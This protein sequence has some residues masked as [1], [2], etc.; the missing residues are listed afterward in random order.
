MKKSLGLAMAVSLSI[1]SLAACGNGNDQA[2]DI[3]APDGATV[4]EFWAAA[5]PLQ[6]TFWNKVADEFNSEQDEIHVEVSQ[7]RETPTSEATVQSALASDSAPTLSENI[8]RGFASQLADSQALVPLNELAGWDDIIANRNMADTV[9]AWEF[10]DG[11]Q[12][13]LPIYSNSM[14]FGWRI[15]ILNELGFEE[16][17]RTYSD[18]YEV[19]DALKEEHPDK[20]LWAKSELASP[21]A[22]ARWFDF[23]PLYAAASGGNNFIEGDSFIGDDDAGQQVLDFLSALQEKKWTADQ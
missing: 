6:E 21:D 17:P 8:N 13:V 7:M 11:N 12:Y 19:V 10:A 16:A 15:D 1:V 23:F 3:Q 14:L 18:V 20:F 2:E 4:I 22:G 5:N 9:E